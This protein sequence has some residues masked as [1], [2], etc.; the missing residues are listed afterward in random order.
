MDRLP[1]LGRQSAI[2]NLL[3][4]FDC[5]AL[6]RRYRRRIGC[7]GR[8]P[9]RSV[10]GPDHLRGR[11]A[12]TCDRSRSLGGAAAGCNGK[13]HLRLR[14]VLHSSDAQFVWFA[15]GVSSTVPSSAIQRTGGRGHLRN[16][17]K[18]GSSTCLQAKA[19]VRAV[20]DGPAG[21]RD[22][23]RR[24]VCFGAERDV[25]EAGVC[26]ADPCRTRPAP[27]AISPAQCLRGR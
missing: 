13:W 11:R 10:L 9:V 15:L 22:Q 19:T 12:G 2:G 4:P 24:S 20:P 27:R 1:G 23:Q 8:R 6:G 5:R 18:S 16:G 3:R 26:D 21:R 14:N 7:R 25:S 17:R